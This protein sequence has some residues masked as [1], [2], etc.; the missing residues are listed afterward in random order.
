MKTTDFPQRPVDLRVGVSAKGRRLGRIAFTTG[1]VLL[2]FL[3][4]LVPSVRAEAFTLNGIQL[5]NGTCGQDLQIGA[6][7]SASSTTTPSFLLSGDGGLSSYSASIDGKGLGTFKSDGYGNVCLLDT[8]VLSEGAHQLTVAELAPRPSNIIGPYNFDVD[9]VP[10]AAPAGLAIDLDSDTGVQGDDITSYNDPNIDGTSVPSVQIRILENGRLVGGALALSSGQ[11]TAVTNPLPAGVN[12]LTAVTVNP[13]GVQS[14]ASPVLAVTIMTTP[15]PAPPTPVLDPASGSGNTPSVSNPTVDGSGALPQ[16]PM[17][18]FV[19]GGEV[20]TTI[21]SGS[22]AWSLTLPVLSVG[23]HTVTATDSDVAG[24]VSAQSSSLSLTLGSGSQSVPGTPSLSATAGNNSVSLSWNVPSDP[25]PPVTSYDVYRATS[26]GAETLLGS[27]TTTTDTDTT[28]RNGTNYYYEVSALNS[29]G[30]GARS[31]EVVATPAAPQTVPAAPSVSDTPGNNAVSLN[32][33]IPANGG[34]PISFY[35]VYRGTSPG[36]ET[37]FG[38]TTATTYADTSAR[39]GT[40]YYYEVCAINGVGQGPLSVPVTAIPAGSGQAPAIVSAPTATAKVRRAFS[41]TVTAVGSPTPTFSESG[42]LPVGVH[43]NTATG[44]FSG[45]AK[46]GA[47]GT[48]KVVISAVNS[49]GTAIQ[50]F[51]LRVTKS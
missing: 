11:W 16:A 8:T 27:T 12:D 39:N 30:Q 48:H 42:A 22:G 10:L 23:T 1:T 6:D 38:S 2:V 40:T 32:W 50:T 24:N 28:A 45:T 9:A 18:V 51:T 15:P 19:D 46:A 26:S 4:I 14:A 13:A 29:V 21:S 36:A 31:A 17:A 43:F 35:D 33:S 25:G 47:K 44:V 5:D 7:A 49:M 41:F 37:L 34:S 20:G 3:A